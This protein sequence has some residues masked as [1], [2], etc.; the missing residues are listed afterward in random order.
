VKK[1]EGS[2]LSEKSSTGVK[3]PQPYSGKEGERGLD[4]THAGHRREKKSFPGREEEKGIP[5]S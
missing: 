3:R 2:F 5:F 4:K 1:K